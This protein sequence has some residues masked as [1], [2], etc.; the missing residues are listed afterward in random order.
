MS[1]LTLKNIPESLLE[2]LRQHAEEDRRSLTQ[3]VLYLLEQAVREKREP[4]REY[5]SVAEIS[6]QCDEWLRIA[7]TWDSARP[8]AEE[9]EEIYASR[10]S[11]RNVEL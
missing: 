11:G 4:L 3:E 9:I 8:I 1:S 2:A 10:T 5:L 6:K 7:G